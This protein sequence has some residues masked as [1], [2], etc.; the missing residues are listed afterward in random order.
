MLPL[1]ALIQFGG[2]ITSRAMLSIY[3]CCILVS[4]SLILV[5][6]SI[7]PSWLSEIILT[8][9]LWPLV[10]QGLNPMSFSL[11]ES[12]YAILAGGWLFIIATFSIG[13]RVLRLTVR[14]KTIVTIHLIG[15]VLALCILLIFAGQSRFIASAIIVIA[16][17]LGLAVLGLYH[18]VNVAFQMLSRAL[19]GSNATERPTAST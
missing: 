2:F 7:I 16:G 12:S 4:F 5:T 17:I 18:V 19:D 6:T 13:L 15:V 8:A 1:K 11:D 14:F 9:I 3:I 10:L